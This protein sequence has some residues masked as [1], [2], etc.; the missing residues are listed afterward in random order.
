MDFD[1]PDALSG[2]PE[3]AADLFEGLRLVVG[4]AVAE[5]D[6]ASL[7]IGEGGEAADERLAPE[8]SLD[9]VLR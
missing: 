8:R 3:R 9:L 4:Q 5:A 1:L 7:T 6:H 2:Q